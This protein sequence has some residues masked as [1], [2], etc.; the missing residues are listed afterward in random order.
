MY[1]RFSIDHTS[2]GWV[3]FHRSHR[4]F[5]THPLF[6]RVREAVL[7]AR[8]AA[9]DAAERSARAVGV[10]G[11]K[12]AAH[13]VPRRGFLSTKASI[14]FA[15]VSRVEFEQ[16]PRHDPEVQAYSGFVAFVRHR[17]VRARGP[18]EDANLPDARAYGS[19]VLR[20]GLG[21]DVQGVF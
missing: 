6:V 7:A 15:A 2:R 10:G 21:L 16:R 19:E 9:R 8:R 5:V 14:V 11:G 13:A 20:A 4:V 1:T 18:V 17:V 3:P 12:V